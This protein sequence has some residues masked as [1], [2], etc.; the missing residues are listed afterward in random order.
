MF[1]ME[2]IQVK[3]EQSMIC[4]Q[5]IEVFSIVFLRNMMMKKDGIG[6]SVNIVL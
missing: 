3:F 2:C 4:I 5:D 1:C 6:N